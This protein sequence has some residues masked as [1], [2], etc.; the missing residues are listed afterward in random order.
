[1]YTPMIPP[2]IFRRCLPTLALLALFALPSSLP[3][4]EPPVWH[5]HSVDAT[6]QG[7]DGVRT[8]D[9]NRDGWPDVTTGWE[10][11]GEVR[12]YL[13]PGPE[14]VREPWPRVT[15]GRVASPEDAVFV[16]LDGDGAIDVVSSCEGKTKCM[17]VHWAPRDPARILDADAWETAAIPATAGRAWMFA[18]PLDGDGRRGVDLVVGSKNDSACIGWLESPTNP[19]DLSAW[20]FHHLRD[21]GWVMSLVPSD[22]DGDGDL[23]IVFS[24]R[25]GEG[26]GAYWLE[27]PGPTRAAAGQPWP[28]HPI[29]GHDRE[30]MFLSVA[31]LDDDGRDEVLVTTWNGHFAW[32][33]HESVDRWREHRHDFPYGA[34]RGKSQAVGDIDLDGRSDLVQVNRGDDGLRGIVWFRRTGA[35]ESLELEA[36]D[37]GG[38]EGS[39]FDLVELIDLDGDGDLDLLTC[40]EKDNLGVIWY[41]NP[42]AVE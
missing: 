12:V 38:T 35:G 30:L 18:Q 15:V 21:A 23:D 11:G 27:Y 24:D 7:A 37:I 5:R 6:S 29:G 34:T 1:M 41:E 39:K 33:T 40:E 31:D 4:G 13:H 3:G 32:F 10:E 42:F 17:F 19:R 22:V 2:R 36:H 16:D 25:R 9:V 26:R 20:R 14:R 8:A 28:E